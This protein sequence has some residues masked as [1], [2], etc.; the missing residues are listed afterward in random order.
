MAHY[1][2]L[3]MGKSRRDG[4]LAILSAGG[5]NKNKISCQD[6]AFTLGP[7][8]NAA[9]RLE[10]PDFAFNTLTKRGVQGIANA[11][12]LERINRKRKTFIATV[13]RGVYAKLE[14]REIGKV[15]VIGDKD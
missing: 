7:R 13:M 3:V 1:G 12:E 14:K 2:K 8:I 11:K 10:H 9:G 15:V 5:L 4:L 6:I